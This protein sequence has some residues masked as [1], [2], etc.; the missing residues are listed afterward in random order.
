LPALLLALLSLHA[1]VSLADDDSGW[2]SDSFIPSAPWREQQA[3][4]PAYPEAGRLLEVAVSSGNYPYRVYIDPESLSVG[5][6]R[7]VRYAAVIVSAAGARNVTYEGLRCTTRKYRRYAYGANGGWQALAEAPWERIMESGMGRYR[8]ELYR[9]YLCDTTS[10]SLKRDEILR[11]L[12][13]SRG[14]V[15]DE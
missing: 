3:D 14:G 12:R 4:L 9:D 7:V 6:D 1:L 5:A 2:S 13:Y 8:F 11:R 10:D 15:V